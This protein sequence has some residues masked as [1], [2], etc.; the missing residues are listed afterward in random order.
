MKDALAGTLK[1]IAFHSI[2][3]VDRYSHSILTVSAVAHDTSCNRTH[4]TISDVG[5]KTDDYASMDDAI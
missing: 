1:K 5:E 4:L 3:R 2:C